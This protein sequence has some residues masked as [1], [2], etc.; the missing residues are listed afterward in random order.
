MWWR[1]CLP[2]GTIVQ[3][4]VDEFRVLKSAIIQDLRI[5]ALSDA[6]TVK[7]TLFRFAMLIGITEI[8]WEERRQIFPVGATG[9]FS[10]ILRCTPCHQVTF[11]QLF[12]V[13]SW[14]YQQLRKYQ[15][16]CSR[17]THTNPESRN[18]SNKLIESFST[19]SRVRVFRPLE[20]SVPSV[21]LAR[22]PEGDAKLPNDFSPRSPYYFSDSHVILHNGFLF[23]VCGL[24]FEGTLWMLLC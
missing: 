24:C 4:R 12:L 16:S 3:Q 20:H 8:S 23:R 2:A 19:T 15:A 1:M 5:G 9:L 6:L 10:M 14:K 21:G 11:F 22:P 13:D 17:A 7:H 18:R